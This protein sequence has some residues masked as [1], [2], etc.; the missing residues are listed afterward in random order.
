MPSRKLI[1]RIEEIKKEIVMSSREKFDYENDPLN[2]KGK[3]INPITRENYSPKYKKTAKE[4]WS[5]LPVYQQASSIL[6][7]IKGHDVILISSGTG[8]GKTVIMPNLLLSYFDWDKKVVVALP[9]QEVTKKATATA[10]LVLDVPP[11]SPKIA[12]KYQ[13]SAKDRYSAKELLLLYATTMSIVNFLLKDPALEDF[14]G[15]IIDEAHE[16]KIEIDFLLFMLRDTILLRKKSGKEFKLIIMSA[17]IDDTLFKRYFVNGSNKAITFKTLQISGKSNYPIE[18]IY[19]NYPVK[20]FDVQKEVI[21]IIEKIVVHDKKPGNIIVFVSSGTQANKICQ[22]VSS[23]PKLS[24]KVFCVEF[25]SKVSDEKKFL[26]I[27]EHEYKKHSKNKDYRK[28]VIATELAESSVTID[29]MMFVIDTGKAYT[30]RYDPLSRADLCNSDFV[31]KSNILQRKGRVG[32]TAP[33]T[34]YH[35]YTKE[36]YDSLRE[37]SA[38]S[39][40]TDDITVN[41]LTLL[42]QNIKS[43]ASLKQALKEFIEP[44]SPLYVKTALTILK[45]LKLINATAITPFGK[46]VSNIDSSIF[47]I[48]LSVALAH[49]IKAKVAFET[50]KVITILIMARDGIAKTLFCNETDFPKFFNTDTYSNDIEAIYSNYDNP[51]IKPLLKKKIDYK[52]NELTDLIRYKETDEKKTKVLETMIKCFSLA[53]AGNKA[54]LNKNGKYTISYNTNLT[55]CVPGENSIFKGSK[56]PLPKSILF[57]KYQPSFNNGLDIII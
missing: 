40:L 21:K 13:G 55:H 57:Y 6:A 46:V 50:L 56:N 11:S 25:Y 3:G 24:D 48:R 38:P 9:K 23:N 43:I 18:S 41:C 54:T 12:L 42:S 26:A 44:P 10:N 35:L 32:R 30:C 19:H 8:S 53:F 2:S 14:S 7:D 15:V 22:E 37:Y 33:G 49:A 52:Y 47:N 45:D 27:D 5:K 4:F 31:A 1:N 29:G 28:L 39:I 51:S 16:R 20:P 17:T 34:C 36:K